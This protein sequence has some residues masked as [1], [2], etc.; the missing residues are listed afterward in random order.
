MFRPVTTHR[1]HGFSI[2]EIFVIATIIAA[3]SAIAIPNWLGFLRNQRM[4]TA[5]SDAVSAIRLAQAGARREKLP[6]TI[7]FRTNSN[8]VQW[9]ANRATIPTANWQWS[10]LTGDSANQIQISS[11]A[12]NFTSVSGMYQFTFEFNGRVSPGATVPAR[13]TFQPR[14]GNLTADQRCVRIITLLGAIR[15]DNG[16][17]CSS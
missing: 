8:R 6:W 17:V 4:R 16:S 9:T 3:V 11:S 7:A 10:D 14:E 12:T 13:I 2:A 1:N 15:L 5:Q